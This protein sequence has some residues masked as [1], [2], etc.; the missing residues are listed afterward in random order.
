VFE[1]PKASTGYGPVATL[2][3]FNGANGALPTPFGALISDAAGDLFGTTQDGGANGYGTV[4]ELTGTGF[5]VAVTPT[6]TIS[7][8]I[9]L[10]GSKPSVTVSGVATD[11]SSPLESVTVNGRSTNLLGNG[12]AWTYT[13]TNLTAG[14]HTYVA[15]ITDQAGKSI[16]RYGERGHRH[17]Q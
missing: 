4:F 2:L 13:E 11:S 14:L 12:G 9:T 8:T 6:S 16:E 15:T 17:R 3:S 5:Q 10:S 1:I 7:E